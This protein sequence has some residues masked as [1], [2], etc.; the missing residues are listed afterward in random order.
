VHAVLFDGLDPVDAI[1]LLMSRP[2]KH[3]RLAE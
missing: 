1:G 2:Q 3:E